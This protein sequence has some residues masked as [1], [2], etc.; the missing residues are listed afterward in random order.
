MHADDSIQSMGGKARN[1]ALSAEQRSEI[2]RKAS[3]TRW[4]ALQLTEFD[5]DIRLGTGE[6]NC[7][8]IEKDGEIIRVINSR[9]FLQALGRPWKGTYKRTGMPSFIDA[10]NLNPFI[11]SEL[12]DVLGLIEYRTVH[13]GAKRGY[14]AAIVPLVCEV[15]LA[16]RDAGAITHA[17]QLAVAK[18]CELLTRGLARVGIDALVDEATGYQY[19]RERWAL[20]RILEKFISQELQPW[21]RTFPLEFYQQIFRLREWPFNPQTMQGPR[22]LAK[23]TNDIVYKRLAPGVLEE[24]RSKNPLIDG[25]RKHK[26]FQ[27]L[28]GEVGHPKLLA[29]LEGV[30]ILMRECDSWTQFQTKLDRH[31]PIIET[32]D[33]GFV[34]EKGRKPK[35]LLDS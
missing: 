32:A 12:R 30:K 3:K 7:S 29:H 22:V 9:S 33:L 31:Y 2:A 16:A 27:W 20:A 5:G 13:G 21:T 14:R 4:G 1:L 11:T 25:R 15:Y 10:P 24:L 8:V 23:Y 26:H 28:T 18:A 34:I 35:L 19:S 6:I 17:R